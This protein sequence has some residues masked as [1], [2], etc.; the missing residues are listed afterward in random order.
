MACSCTEALT[1]RDFVLALLSRLGF[2]VNLQKSDLAPFQ[3]LTFLGLH[4]DMQS[5]K[6]ALTDKK[7]LKFQRAASHLVA[8]NPPWTW[9]LQKFLGLSNSAAYMV[10]RARL[11]SWALQFVPSASYKC[12]SDHFR[13]CQISL[14]ASQELQW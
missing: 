10:P 8:S 13:V 14:E 4:W 6:T 1:Q 12:P 9:D 11:C 7:V 5:G 2:L 3:R